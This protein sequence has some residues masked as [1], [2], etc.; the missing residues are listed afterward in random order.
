MVKANKLVLLYI[1]VL[2]AV[3]LLPALTMPFI[4][5]QAREK[6]ENRKLTT[7]PDLT[8]VI[9][10]PKETFTQ[11]DDFVNDHLGGG[12]Q[13]I[14]ARRKFYFESFGATNDIYIVGNNKG[15]YFLTAPF[16]QRDRNLPFSWWNNICVNAQNPNYQKSYLERFGKSEGFLSR[17][18][19]EVVYG[20]VPS[21]A[22]L[23]Q[24]QLPKST[25]EK[26]LEACKDFSATNNVA[27]SLTETNPDLNIFYPYSAFKERVSDPLFYPN[28]AYHWQGESTW[29][30]TE[31]LAKKYN[32][33]VSSKWDKGPCEVSDVKWD[34]GGLIGVGK[35][36]TGCDRDL[37]GLGIEIDEKFMYPLKDGASKKAVRVVKMTNPYVSNDKSAIVFSN[38][39]GPAV[40]QQIASHFKTTYHLR[41]GIINSPNM[42]ALLNES[43]I[44]DV[45]FI[46]VTV[47]DFHY[48]GFLGWVEP[49]KSDTVSKRDYN[50][51]KEEEND[52]LFDV[53]NV[54]RPPTE[55][56]KTVA[57]RRANAESKA[58]RQARQKAQREKKA[59]AEAKR[60]AKD[61]AND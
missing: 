44:L 30:F 1:V 34:I 36:T 6:W 25:P 52:E 18:G 20:M 43:D 58:E 56:R 16:Q 26:T 31:E 15:A 50:A 10:A 29:V 32:L 55:R 27:K 53:E 37:E 9:K 13:V 60:K 40:R 12:F 61:A 8:Q 54:Q 14:K 4:D 19:A 3:L 21:K 7:R 47:A 11:V 42:K 48:P 33:E 23:L 35:E 49:S 46:I 45:D 39:F 17:Y 22:V 38:S 28:T 2:S 51:A 59:A 24:D 57:E 41:G 5:H